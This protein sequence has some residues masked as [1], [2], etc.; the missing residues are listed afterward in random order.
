MFYGN[1]CSNVVWLLSSTVK[2]F[3][4][5]NIPVVFKYL[6]Q[7]EKVENSDIGDYM[8]TSFTP[9]RKMSAHLLFK[10]NREIFIRLF[11]IKCPKRKKIYFSIDSFL[12]RNKHWKIHS[13]KKSSH[14]ELSKNTTSF[15]CSRCF[16]IQSS[17]TNR[18]LISS[19]FCFIQGTKLDTKLYYPKQRE[20]LFPY[21]PFASGKIQWHSS[22]MKYIEQRWLRWHG[23]VNVCTHNLFHFRLDNFLFDFCLSLEKKFFCF[24]KIYRANL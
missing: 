18:L 13:I 11:Y 16:R 12:M 14:V 20:K 7:H 24:Q 5:V 19:C 3:P 17:V 23:L 10:L 6:I 4:C 9:L 1:D 21:S 8:R 15:K 22:F 2:T